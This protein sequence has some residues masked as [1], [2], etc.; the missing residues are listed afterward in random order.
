M[1]KRMLPF[2][3]RPGLT[4]LA[5]VNSYDGMSEDQKIKWDCAYTEN[6]TFTNDIKIKTR[7]RWIMLENNIVKPSISI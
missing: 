1:R 2:G 7:I 5:Q 6:I 3:V 4:G